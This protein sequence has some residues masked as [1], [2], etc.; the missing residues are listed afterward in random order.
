M[1]CGIRHH[2]ITLPHSQIAQLPLAIWQKLGGV[3]IDDSDEYGGGGD[4]DGNGD[5]DHDEILN[6][7]LLSEI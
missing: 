4:Y 5:D 3:V 6:S 7:K 2:L 1:K